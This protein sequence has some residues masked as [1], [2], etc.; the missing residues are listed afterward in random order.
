[1]AKNI[2]GLIKNNQLHPLTYRS[3]TKSTKQDVY[4]NLN[5]NPEGKILEFDISKEINDEQSIMQ[6]QF[7]NG[8]MR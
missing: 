6:N 8:K 7:I 3:K 4:T 1:M 5:F 2:E